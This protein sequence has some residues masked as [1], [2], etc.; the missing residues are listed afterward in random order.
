MRDIESVYAFVVETRSRLM[1]TQ[2]SDVALLRG[3]FFAQLMRRAF[4]QVFSQR[5]CDAVWKAVSG[6][7]EGSLIAAA[8]GRGGGVA[9]GDSAT[10]PESLL[11][12]PSHIGWAFQFWNEPVRDQSS[13][14]VSKR[15]MQQPAQ[16]RVEALTQLFT[17]DYIADFIC[18]R[19]IE[20]ASNEHRAWPPRVFDP[21]VGTGHLLLAAIRALDSR[22]V[23]LEE[24]IS[25]VH[26]CDIDPEV[27]TLARLLILL[28]LGHRGY[29]GNL[30]RAWEMLRHSIV[31]LPPA[32]G[33][34]DRASCEAVGITQCE[35]VVTN[36]PYLGRR[37]LDIPMRDFLDRHYPDACVDLSA[38][39]IQRCVELTVPGGALGLVTSE[40]WLRLRG[41]K[42]LREGGNTFPG[43]F[44]E[45]S[46]D[47]I[48]ELGERAFH[49]IVAL[50]DGL[51][52]SILCGRR[53]PPA[54]DHTCAFLR[55]GAVGNY[56]EKAHLLTTQRIKGLGSEHRASVRQTDLWEDR[57]AA[58]FL[59]AHGLPG[60][61]VTS[62]ATVEDY[63]DVVVGIQTSDD[64]RFVRYHWEVAPE[65][66][67][68]RVHNKGGGYG[69]WAGLNRWVI[70]WPQGRGA[71]FKTTTA[72]KRADEWASRRGWTY[73][74]FANGSLGL[75]EKQ[76]GWSFG[77]AA[78]SGIFC[79]DERLVSFLNS[80]AAS[81]A[82][83]ALGGKIQLPEG[84]VRRVPVPEDLS[85]I[86]VEWQSTVVALRREM[87]ASE[88]TDVLFNPTVRRRWFDD[89][90]CEALILSAEGILEQQ[91]ENSIGV[92]DED[93]QA[94]A[95]AV[96]VPVAWFPSAYALHDHPLWSLVSQEWRH[97]R[98]MIGPMG[99]VRESRLGEATPR[100]DTIV[101][102]VIRGEKIDQARRY[103]LP[104]AG[105]VE[106][107]SRMVERHPFD[108][109]LICINSTRE[110][111]D[112]R[113]GLTMEWVHRQIVRDLLVSL[114][115]QWWSDTTHAQGIP[116]STIS[117]SDVEAIAQ[118]YMRQVGIDDILT[119]CRAPWVTSVFM[120][121]QQRR[122]AGC[123]PLLIQRVDGHADRVTHAWVGQPGSV[124]TSALSR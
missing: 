41:Y 46:L 68:W 105:W 23:A 85:S 3:E 44:R 4:R 79:R 115:H 65:P 67:V 124:A 33:T 95:A 43:L 117:C 84:V 86:D 9:V 57:S 104:A 119:S 42:S 90:I 25:R 39:F 60:Q 14:A 55:L 121:W 64:E 78:A 1:R 18:S 109:A 83:R 66:K 21:A 30:Q 99:V 112:T 32:A 54:S 52:A 58:V 48:C 47:V 31:V 36:P 16:A 8:L 97:L 113:R 107:I 69:R 2:E 59:R 82:C 10:V 51:K 13:W 81:L 93:T 88:I 74:W 75:R 37:K 27:V 96:G 49:P 110:C 12:Y 62:R 101:K 120:P 80:R 92:S 116:C 61:L 100:D 6:V 7:R 77:R 17:D 45:V 72:E 26:G 89:L 28:E 29:R 73:T 20:L 19:C 5:D 114:G 106:K 91:I 108:V 94:F 53:I 111:A 70:E 56:E 71:F 103:A 24:I 15:T 118:T 40:T 38:A 87:L 63:A 50:H 102:R 35:V 22:G 11:K 123:S 34:L 76:A 98:E 122:F